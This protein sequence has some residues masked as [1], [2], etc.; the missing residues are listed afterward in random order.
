[1]VKKFGNE[2]NKLISVL[3]HVRKRWKKKIFQL[4]NGHNNC[5][6]LGCGFLWTIPTFHNFFFVVLQ[7]STIKLL[8]NH[9]W[10][11][12]QFFFV[13]QSVE[14][15]VEHFFQSKYFTL[16]FISSLFHYPTNN[17]QIYVCQQFLLNFGALQSESVFRFFPARQVSEIILNEYSRNTE[18]ALSKW[19]GK[20]T[21]RYLTIFLP[22]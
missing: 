10:V 16:K 11:C 14:Q 2:K 19:L 8:V 22:K 5:M 13:E 17:E 21:T 6:A 9:V 18:N 15:S 20:E 1:M 12:G 7:F 3:H 4:R